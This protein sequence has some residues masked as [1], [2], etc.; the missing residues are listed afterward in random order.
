VTQ[1]C[2]ACHNMLA[3]EEAAPKVLVELGLAQ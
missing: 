2:A 1:D 3:M